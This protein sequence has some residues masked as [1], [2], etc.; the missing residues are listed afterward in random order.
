MTM[1]LLLVIVAALF[2]KAA[3]V[4]LE[5]SEGRRGWGRMYAR[6]S[7][8]VAVGN[9]AGNS[10][11]DEL[12]DE[13]DLREGSHTA[14]L[15]G[16][17][18][19]AQEVNKLQTDSTSEISKGGSGDEDK[20]SN[21]EK[22]E[23]KNKDDNEDTDNDKEDKAQD[24][25]RQ[26]SKDTTGN[27]Y[28]KLSNKKTVET[29]KIEQGDRTQ[30]AK[31]KA[32]RKEEIEKAA[33]AKSQKLA[34][35]KQAA[36][37][38]S[39]KLCKVAGYVP[40]A[41]N[42]VQTMKA[43]EPHQWVPGP[44]YSKDVL[45]K[46][47]SMLHPVWQAANG[48]KGEDG[49][50][51]WKEKD[52][53]VIQFP[54][55]TMVYDS[56]NKKVDPNNLL[57]KPE[58]ESYVTLTVKGKLFHSQQCLM[59]AR[60]GVQAC[61]ANHQPLDEGG[62]Q[63][64]AECKPC[65]QGYVLADVQTSLIR[66]RTNTHKKAAECDRWFTYADTVFRNAFSLFSS[67]QLARR[68]QK[69]RNAKL[70]RQTL[71]SKMQSSISAKQ[72]SLKSL[73]KVSAV[74][75][76]IPGYTPKAYEMLHMLLKGG[77]TTG[78]VEVTAEAEELGE[79]RPLPAYSRD[80]M[81]GL[82]NLL[83][84]KW[85][86]KNG[87]H[88]GLDGKGRDWTKKD[89]LVIRFGS[90]AT[91]DHSNKKVAPHILLQNPG[92]ESYVTLTVTGKLFEPQQCSMEARVSVQVCPASKQSGTQDAAQCKRCKKGYTVA[93]VQTSLIEGK[94]AASCSPWFVYADTVFRTAFSTVSS[95]E[96]AGR[97]KKCSRK[98]RNS[99]E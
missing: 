97:V 77:N 69:C 93:D 52:A 4:E 35:K 29:L 19:F 67:S 82:Q 80:V 38:C 99:H 48:H 85:K 65:K 95:S 88:M 70:K 74:S 15:D 76:Q 23:D 57:D 51:Q 9:R 72:V 7:F 55:G 25:K 59:E 16:S 32:N 31:A 79:A 90:I 1:R 86:L 98:Q 47:Q 41:Y 2:D 42:W 14:A 17:Q 21:T 63:D 75:N 20:D 60:V 36:K 68:I 94:E 13:F 12:E 81:E 26:Q 61:P 45:A 64:T 27:M 39:A 73:Q 96:N 28:K 92:H 71:Q 87:Q 78:K 46:L 44:K 18:E 56:S 6:S 33:K 58:S 37:T 83:Y 89:A 8:F 54:P 30:E 3:G 11:D 62:T 10:E 50:R 5:E 22:N 40:A 53:L 66:G 43:E 91:Y 84:P 34:K 49:Q 24:E